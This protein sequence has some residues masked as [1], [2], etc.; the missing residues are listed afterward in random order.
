MSRQ[1]RD[2][3]SS[4]RATARVLFPLRDARP[5]AWL[6]LLAAACSFVAVRALELGP[7]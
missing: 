3:E 4:R 2:C 5:G 6:L 7:F 1:G